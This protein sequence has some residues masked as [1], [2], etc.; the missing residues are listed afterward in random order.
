MK[1]AK[2]EKYGQTHKLPCG[3]YERQ[4]PTVLGLFLTVTPAPAAL[5]LVLNKN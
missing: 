2:T 5:G 4:A 3:L 1:I